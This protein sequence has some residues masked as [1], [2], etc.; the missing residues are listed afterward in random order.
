VVEMVVT[1]QVVVIQETL[2]DQVVVL[3]EV[4]IIK[5]L[6]LVILLQ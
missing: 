1:I 2:E 6:E 5:M 4:V 3:Q